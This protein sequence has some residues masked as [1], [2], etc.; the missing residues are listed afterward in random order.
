MT[1][2]E[3]ISPTVL[4]AIARDVYVAAQLIANLA[5]TIGCHTEEAMRGVRPPGEYPSTTVLNDFVEVLAEGF[6]HDLDPALLAY[7]R[8]WLEIG[9]HSI[10][11]QD[12]IDWDE[13]QRRM[14]DGDAVQ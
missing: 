12:K 4:D 2:E 5:H 14:T 9:F 10:D 1:D 3:R 6:G 7:V 8:F 11:E 13:Q